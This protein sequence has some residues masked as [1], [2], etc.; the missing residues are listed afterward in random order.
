MDTYVNFGFA[1]D[2]VVDPVDCV[3]QRQRDPGAPAQ[4][5]KDVGSDLVERDDLDRLGDRGI[6]QV[7]RRHG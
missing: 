6:E 2:D 3:G 7:T 4:R 5:R 1:W